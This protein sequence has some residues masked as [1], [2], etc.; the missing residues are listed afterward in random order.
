MSERKPAHRSARGAP[1][2]RRRPIVLS[3]MVAVSDAPGA[4]AWYKRALGA[5]ELWSLGAVAGLEIA[6]APFF[7][8]EPE[9]N[10]WESP[11]KLGVREGGKRAAGVSTDEVAAQGAG[12]MRSRRGARSLS[13]SAWSRS[14]GFREN[15][16]AKV[17]T[18][19]SPAP[20]ACRMTARS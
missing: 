5:V 14:R 13:W 12:G 2:P 10:G 8:G 16:R 18:A 3:V 17:A 19:S 9:T 6:G 1:R 20:F 11:A 15:A 7:V 4:V